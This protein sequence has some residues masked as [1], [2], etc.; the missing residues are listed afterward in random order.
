MAIFFPYVLFALFCVPLFLVLRRST[1][2]LRV[3]RD[4]PDETDSCRCCCCWSTGPP[5]GSCR[6]VCAPSAVSSRFFRRWSDDD[7]RTTTC[8]ASCGTDD[9]RSAD[10]LLW[11]RS[12]YLCADC[13]SVVFCCDDPDESRQ[14][15]HAFSGTKKNASRRYSYNS[16]SDSLARR[17]ISSFSMWQS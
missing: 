17:K 5:D 7:L 16:K 11:L 8:C 15:Q 13:E 9:A 10:N 4:D 14:Y 1:A 12:L 6:L 2:P 3:R